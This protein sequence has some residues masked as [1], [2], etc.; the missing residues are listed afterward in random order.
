MFCSN[1]QTIIIILMASSI[2]FVI[3]LPQ[4]TSYP[5]NYTLPSTDVVDCKTMFSWV[6][7]EQGIYCKDSQKVLHKCLQ[8]ADVGQMMGLNCYAYLDW[9]D[10]TG[11]TTNTVEPVVPCSAWD[12]VDKVNGQK[13]MST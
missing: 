2:L 5:K 7:H 8:R 12:T 4:N 1:L 13:Y 3:G 6:P 9:K 10:L 11:Y